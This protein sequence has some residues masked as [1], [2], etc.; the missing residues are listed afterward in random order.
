LKIVEALLQPDFLGI[1]PDGPV[2]EA[3]AVK[4]SQVG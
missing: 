1:R 3:E 2:I 4:A